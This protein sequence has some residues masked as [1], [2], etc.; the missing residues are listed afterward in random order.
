ML[1]SG[2]VAGRAGHA[3]F[4]LLEVGLFLGILGL[5]RVFIIH[6]RGQ[7][8]RLPSDLADVT[9]LTYKSD[10]RDG[11]LRA[12]IGP[13]ANAIRT[14]IASDGLRLRRELR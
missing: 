10:R 14:R 8:L 7:G 6:P 9:C 13:A 3:R 1:M 2:A 4:A 12:A 5:R 11:N